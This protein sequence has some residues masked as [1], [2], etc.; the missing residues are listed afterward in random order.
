MAQK[1]KTIGGSRP[2]VP[3]MQVIIRKAYQAVT[4]NP[5]ISHKARSKVKRCSQIAVVLLN[6]P[7]HDDDE[8]NDA[9]E[10]KPVHHHHRRPLPSSVRL[11]AQQNVNKRHS[12]TVQK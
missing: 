1:R 2:H 8:R 6:D 11:G 3:Q 10:K 7:L 9:D 5:A 12:T 4:M